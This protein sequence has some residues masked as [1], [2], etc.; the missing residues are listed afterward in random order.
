MIRK[1]K[2]NWI[3]NEQ[4]SKMHEFAIVDNQFTN[5]KA[6]VAFVISWEYIGLRIRLIL[7]KIL[8]IFLNL[9]FWAEQIKDWLLDL[10]IL[11]SFSLLLSSYLT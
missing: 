5:I 1:H 11:V 7:F 3:T 8:N 6:N 9:K 10:P 4:Y 2:S